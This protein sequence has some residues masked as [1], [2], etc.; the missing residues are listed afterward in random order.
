MMEIISR[1]KF[2]FFAAVL[3]LSTYAIFYEQFLTP[4]NYFWSS[5]GH[6]TDAQTKHL[7]AR[8]YLYDRIVNERSFPFWTEKMYSGFPVYADPE[9]AYLNPINVASTLIFGPRMS[10]KVLHILE[11]LAGS[12]SLYF[13]LKRKGIGLLGY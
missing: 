3:S 10:Y 6:P 9:N 12:L 11:Y 8:T 4:S 2:F 7:P 1:H 5:E 13:L